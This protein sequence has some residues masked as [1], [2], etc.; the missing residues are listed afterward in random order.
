MCHSE[1]LVLSFGFGMLFLTES[2][3]HYDSDILVL[4]FWFNLLLV[5]ESTDHCHSQIVFL[6]FWF[7]LLLFFY[8]LKKERKRPTFLDRT[9]SEKVLAPLKDKSKV[10]GDF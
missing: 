9:R 2:A 4:S 6:C 10:R 5:I 1:I 3:E 7:G 8:L